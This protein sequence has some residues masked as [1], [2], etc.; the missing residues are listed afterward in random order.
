MPI[1]PEYRASVICLSSLVIASAFLLLGALI[2][3]APA[4]AAETGA[5]NERLQ[6]MERRMADQQQQIEDL[7]Q[8]LAEAMQ[9]PS[10]AAKTE[11]HRMLDISGFFDITAH[12]TD[13][14]THPFDLGGLELDIQYD[15]EKNIAISTALAWDGDT[16]EVAVAVLDYHVKSHDVP[17]RGRL[18]GEPGYHLQ[19]GR[20]DLPFG[21]DYEFF[22]APDRPNVTAPLT[23]ERTLDG[24][25]NG[26]GIRSYGTW[27]PINYAL[28]WTNSVF[29]DD[30]SSVGFQLGI[31]P[32]RDPFRAHNRASQTDFSFAVS[33]LRDMDERR[34]LRNQ[35]RAFSLSW[36]HAAFRLV[37]EKVDL[38]RREDILLP[39]NVTQPGN[40]EGY[41]ARLHVDVD[42]STLFL[43]VGEWQPDYSQRPDAENPNTAYGVETLRRLTLG[44]RHVFDEFLHVKLEYMTHVGTETQEPDFEP[45]RLTFQ[46]VASF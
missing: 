10:P 35:L 7:R 32:A 43:G 34:N 1:I 46:M 2:P 13:N 30:G 45:R 28:Y 4:V 25:L 8:K 12:T 38:D 44:V 17:T 29:E 27:L 20:F 5:S 40:E 24:G 15:Q 39:G 26:D 11:Q 31:Y 19:F 9:T 42:N 21:I 18:F 22:A 41:N 37:L 3:N 36:S 6:R 33:Y 14:R 23:T 16:S